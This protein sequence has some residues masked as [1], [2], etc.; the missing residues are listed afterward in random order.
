MDKLDKKLKDVFT[1]ENKIPE[2]FTGAIQKAMQSEKRQ[3]T[4]IQY[5]K[6]TKVAAVL[7]VVIL[8]GATT[9]K[10]YAQIKWNIEYKEFENR[11]VEY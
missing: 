3:K 6:W 5:V 8:L 2:Q 9:P 10:I 7:L 11:P 4:R 1:E